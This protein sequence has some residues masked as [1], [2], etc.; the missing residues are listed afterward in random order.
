M[1][2]DPEAKTFKPRQ[3]RRWIPQVPVRQVLAAL[4]LPG[5]YLRLVGVCLVLAW[6][7]WLN[8]AH[9]P[10]VSRF[11]LPKVV[12]ILAA[13]EGGGVVKWKGPQEWLIERSLIANKQAYA[14]RHGYA[15]AI[16]DMT[17]RKRYSHEWREGWEKVDIL[18]QT[19]RQ[20][21]NA[22]WFWWMDLHTLIMEPQR[23]LEEHLLDKL[24]T[25][26]YRTLQQFNPL[27]IPIDLLYVDLTQ[28][29]DMVLTQDC[30]GFNLGLFLVRNTPWL[31]MMLDM[32]WDPA[33]YEQK[34]QE[35]EHR[36]Q[37]CLENLYSDNGW[38]REKVGFVPLRVLNAFPPGACDAMSD[39]PTLF[40]NEKER[41]FVVSMAGCQW[42]RDCWGE[43]EYYKSVSRRLHRKV[44]YKPWTWLG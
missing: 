33:H 17:L 4:P 9:L 3:T 14:R 21:P 41:D 38:I 15:L 44:V 42:G 16:K 12:I 10:F 34:H 22:E 13:N 29:V 27:E 40:Y 30:G 19:M 32:W 28:P 18:R 25:M 8:G 24:D 43:M 11:A 31:E 39:D 1:L 7:V 23:L 26:T 5:R 6:W 36:E 37:D 20:Y 35:W 2:D